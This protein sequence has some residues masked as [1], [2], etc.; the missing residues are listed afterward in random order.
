MS[1]ELQ[2]STNRLNLSPMQMAYQLMQSGREVNPDI[3]EKFLKLEREHADRLAQREFNTALVACQAEM[4]TVLF[5][6]RNDQT[7]SQYTKLESMIAQI[8]PCYTKHGFAPSFSEGE[9]INDGKLR[10]VM[11]HMHHKAGWTEIRLGYYPF[12]ITGPKGTPNKSDI[13][14]TKS[15]NTY[16]QRDML[17]SFFAIVFAGE[18]NDGAAMNEPLTKEETTTLNKLIDQY[19]TTANF[20]PDE[21]ADWLNDKLFPW[22]ATVIGVDRLES[23]AEVPR[24][25]YATIKT[26]LE[27]LVKKAKARKR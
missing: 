22:I 14:G 5:N 2:E 12:D 13:Q 25:K 1:S 23:L 15:S 18:D 3:V 4:K 8:K 10:T 16:A 9:P 17:R 7:K 11:M 24:A 6:A 19:S 20:T 21:S 27:D 26:G